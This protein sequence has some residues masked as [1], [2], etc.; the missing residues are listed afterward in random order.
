MNELEKKVKDLG[1]IQAATKFD[2]EKFDNDLANYLNDCM[3]VWVNNNIEHY[4]KVSW[5]SN[6]GGKNGKSKETSKD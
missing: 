5:D 3:K 4:I 2:A 6:V 1:N